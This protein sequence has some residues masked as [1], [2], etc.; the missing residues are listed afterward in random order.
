MSTVVKI[1]QRYFPDVTTVKD[2]RE[3]IVVEVTKRDNQSAVVR[4]HKACAMAVA[5]KKKM[6]ADGVIVSLSKA[7][8]IKGSVAY[9][10]EV[11]EHAVREIISFDRDAGFAPG[12][13]Q[14][15]APVGNNKIGAIRG[16]NG[17]KT[18]KEPRKTKVVHRKT[19]GIRTV[20]GSGIQ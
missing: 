12:E 11:S 2:A 6:E 10:Y 9:R 1:V 5:C 15:N 17:P 14:L 13:Y 20:L 19:Q 16:G 8:V 3:N 4:N 7:Y 18:G